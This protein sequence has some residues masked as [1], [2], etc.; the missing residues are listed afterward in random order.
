MRSLGLKKRIQ[1]F[2]MLVAMIVAQSCAQFS[3]PKGGPPDE[4]APSMNL[5]ESTPN[6]QTNFD[7]RK[8]ELEFDEWIQLKNPTQEVLVSPPLSYPPKITSRGKK[9]VFE[10]N[11]EE[12]LKDSTTY[13]INFGKSIQDLTAG[14]PVENFIFL[15]STG[16]EIDDLSIGGKVVDSATGKGLKDVVVLMYDDLSDTCFANNKPL[17]LTRTLEEG[18]FK[19]ENLRS[20]TFQIFALKDENV[21][22]TYDLPTEQ[23]AYLDSFI[24]LKDTTLQSLE[25]SMFDEEDD[26]LLVEARQRKRGLINLIYKPPL[27]DYKLVYGC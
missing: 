11:E 15:F 23:V 8:I 6:K 22:Y 21:S 4:T 27:R 13:Q 24:V 10:F 19:L 3:T 1:V 7:Q 5:E 17:Y 16:D 14:N 12:V 18:K 25:L 20:D 9:L 2:S 26:P